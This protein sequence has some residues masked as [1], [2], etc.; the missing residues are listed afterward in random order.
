MMKKKHKDMARL[1]IEN[2]WMGTEKTKKKT[3]RK[4]TK[5]Q[6]G[7]NAF[8]FSLSLERERERER[9]IVAH[10]RGVCICSSYLATGK[11]Q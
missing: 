7:D 8:N 3:L 9:K 6:S 10:V 2:P 5:W 1:I 4:T 11:L